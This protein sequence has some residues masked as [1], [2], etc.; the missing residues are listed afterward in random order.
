MEDELCASRAACDAL[1]VELDRFYASLA[2]KKGLKVAVEAMAR[3]N[4]DLKMARR[5]ELILSA[6]K[7]M[8]PTKIDSGT[9]ERAAAMT[10]LRAENGRLKKQL[11]EKREKEKVEAAAAAEADERFLDLVDEFLAGSGF[12]ASREAFQAE[13]GCRKRFVVT[14]ANAKKRTLPPLE[15]NPTT[16]PAPKLLVF[17]RQFKAWKPDA[18]DALQRARRQLAD[19]RKY[20]TELLVLAAWVSR[21]KLYMRQHVDRIKDGLMLEA[22]KSVKESAWFPPPLDADA[23]REK[24]TEI[25]VLNALAQRLGYAS[26]I[27][28][29][30]TVDVLD[31][32]AIIRLWPHKVVAVV[33]CRLAALKEGRDILASIIVAPPDGPLKPLPCGDVKK[34]PPPDFVT[35]ML[36]HLTTSSQSESDNTSLHCALALQRLSL[37]RIACRRL[38]YVGGLAALLDKVT[39][40]QTSES[41]KEDILTATCCA[42][43]IANCCACGEEFQVADS[44]DA[45]PLG[46][47]AGGTPVY[48]YCYATAQS[49]WQP[50]EPRPPLSE[51]IIEAFAQ[52][53]SGRDTSFSTAAPIA[54]HLLAALSHLPSFDK[55]KLLST[56]AA[57]STFASEVDHLLATGR[58]TKIPTSTTLQPPLLSDCGEIEVAAYESSLEPYYMKI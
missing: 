21:D 7:A 34:W 41:S 1:R 45:L 22:K 51:E 38:I 14:E 28:Q 17:Y 4:F 33:V 13:R 3:E 55:G 18:V 40:L 35:L 32:A 24:S 39:R 37:E 47:V 53:T 43:A 30:A 5:R 36:N 58:T 29:S 50:P 25:P 20:A 8:K 46:W 57:K 49:A 44:P 27:V 16:P 12:E 31:I 54:R 19:T 9:V 6:T 2:A 48:F 56:A 52:T 26:P 15:S 42:A 10:R 11:E 23:V